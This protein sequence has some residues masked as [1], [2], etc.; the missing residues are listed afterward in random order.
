MSEILELNQ[1]KES[2]WNKWLKVTGKKIENDTL[3]HST[4]SSLLSLER[5]LYEV[6]GEA[7]KLRQYEVPNKEYEVCDVKRMVKFR[8]YTSK[9]EL[10]RTLGIEVLSIYGMGYFTVLEG[11]ILHPDTRRLINFDGKDKKYDL[12]LI[13]QDIIDSHD[14]YF[15]VSC[16]G[17]YLFVPKKSSLLRWIEKAYNLQYFDLAVG[18]NFG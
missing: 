3:D 17:N 13:P 15:A 5:S 12:T 14:F 2:Y 16:H 7:I 9:E 10:K 6:M 1:E 8:S 11:I 18:G 4:S